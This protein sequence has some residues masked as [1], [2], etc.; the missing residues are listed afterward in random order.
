M[1]NIFDFLADA[2]ENITFFEDLYTYLALRLDLEA[3]LPRLHTCGCI[4]NTIGIDDIE[5]YFRIRDRHS[6]REVYIPA[7]TYRNPGEITK[8]NLLGFFNSK[9]LTFDKYIEQE[10]LN[11]TDELPF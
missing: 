11:E 8:S 4:I 9:C 10:K 3:I 2:R 6:G 1:T 5:L 7:G